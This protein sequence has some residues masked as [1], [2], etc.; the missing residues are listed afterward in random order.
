MNK[1][2]TLRITK[3][4]Q[5]LLAKVEEISKLQP[6][7]KD[8]FAPM[9]LDVIELGLKSYE[10]GNRLAGGEIINIEN[11]LLLEDSDMN[12]NKPLFNYSHAPTIKNEVAKTLYPT[13]IGII[14]S[15]GYIEKKKETPDESCLA[16][17]KE[18]RNL[19]S[20]EHRRFYMFTDEEIDYKV[21]ILS[22]I[23]K[24][25]VSKGQQYHHAIL[26]ESVSLLKKLEFIEKVA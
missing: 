6:V 21:S 22:P 14:V 19:L 16:F 20:E 2:I 3:R 15:L 17:Y 5:P 12:N 18:M 8:Q 4:S 11:K 10:S 26:E 9:L 23:I 1:T 7:G 25:M 24:E 13:L